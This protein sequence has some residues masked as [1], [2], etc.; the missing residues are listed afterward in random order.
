[1]ALR[2]SQQIF[3]LW[4][5]IITFCMPRAGA[6]VP[7][8]ITEKE[9]GRML[10]L[11]LEILE[12][13]SG[14]LQLSDILLM[15]A[16]FQPSR[17]PVPN[18]GLHRAVQWVK[19]SVHNPFDHPVPILLENT[20]TFVDQFQIYHR[21]ASHGWD[22]KQA[23]DQL[24]FSTRD[25][26][27]RQPV[28]RF[29]LEPGTH[30]F[31]ARS[32]ADG[33]HQL[34]LQLWTHDEFFSHNALEYSYIGILIGFHV[35][36]CLYNLFLFFSLRDKTFL[37]Y[38]IYV[39]SNVIY[40][41]TGLG[42]MQHAL[43]NL[44]LAQHVPNPFMVISV[45]WIAM[46]GLLFSYYFLNI[47]ERLPG[48]RRIY[49]AICGLDVLNMLITTFVS[50]WL[51][52]A[53]CLLTASLATSTLMTSGL[54]VARQR[55]LP[56]YFYLAGWG[57]YLLGVT[58]TVM[59]LVGL[60]S[61][62]E[63]TRWG[64]FTGGAVEIAILSLA[65]GARINAKRRQAMQMIKQLNHELEDKVA[66]RTAEI[67]SLLLHIP[68][69]ILSIGREGRISPNFSAQLPAILGHE[70]IANQSFRTII[71]ERSTLSA[72]ARDQAWQTILASVGEHSLN[73][74]LNIDKLP[75]QLTYTLD[76]MDKE[77]R[78]TWNRELN[79]ND[80]IKHILVTLLD[81]TSEVVAQH[82]VERQNQ[83]FEIIKQ[84]VEIGS[85]KSIQ[86]FSSG[87]QLIEENHRLVHAPSLNPD[88][89][90][91]LFVNTHTLKGAARVLQLQELANALH[92]VETYYSQ[93][94][95]D[96]QPIDQA[97][98]LQEFAHVQ[99]V[100]QRYFRA[101]RDILG[102]RD[103]LKKVVVDRE[104][105]QENIKLLGHLEGIEALPHE[106]HGL[107]HTRR[108]ELT[109]LIFRSIPSILDD[110]MQQAGKI[111]KDLGRE[112]P[113]I[114][115]EADDILVSYS[116]ELALKNAFIHLLRNALDHGIEPAPLRLAKGK[117]AQGTLKVAARE[118]EGTIYIRFEDDGRGLALERIRRLSQAGPDASPEAIAAS[119]FETGFSTTESVTMMSGRGIG[120][121]AVQQFMAAEQ[122]TVRIELG[123]PLDE[124][125]EFRAFS[126]H[127][128][129]PARH[130][131]RCRSGS[132]CSSPADP[133]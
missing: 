64:Q 126:I 92:L 57:C 125:G 79:A 45:D 117:P 17:D 96:Q 22:M 37:Y 32:F 39:A 74:D 21:N 81:V 72:D 63:F 60:A 116:Q 95:K 14:R 124:K 78:L 10:G 69:G 6:A 43:S 2:Y 61:T 103:D 130:A 7:Y 101:H 119:I 20:F 122:G 40:Q 94:L 34:P 41:S 18:W 73:F 83:E 19:F 132:N 31:Y 70:S 91:I 86:F 110:I 80:E 59:N 133:A 118:A 65:L 102:R 42:V 54:L 55:Y 26:Q 128:T 33:S 24:P 111:A 84:L 15:D 27:S 38:V 35:V 71:L 120:L 75:A 13:P 76:G 62:S 85:R 47:E 5:G 98:A 93:V 99:A 89:I 123:P 49:L 67:H 68:Q 11:H 16:A 87:D 127:I 30:I 105:L 100:Y 44:G 113:I 77:L 115:M 53:I 29:T 109:H 28:F 108:S 58:G 56:G 90:R 23:G 97:R 107:I 46:T 25:V 112:P 9:N 12:D 104:I 88:A 131:M 114:H 4:L 52:T 36:I 106:L 121:G 129:L 8:T 3:L 1:M 51:G 50:V 48:F 66:E 82:E